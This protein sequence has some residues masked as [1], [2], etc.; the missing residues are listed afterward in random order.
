RRSLRRTTTE[1]PE[2][3]AP[4]SVDG[5]VYIGGVHRPHQL[6]QRARHQT[7]ARGETSPPQIGATPGWRPDG[8]RKGSGATI[9]LVLSLASCTS[10]PPPREYWDDARRDGSM[11]LH[12]YS[13]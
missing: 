1:A 2:R 7:C 4:S 6:R 12:S 5:G 8:A 11:S 9:R 3:P 13:P 10:T